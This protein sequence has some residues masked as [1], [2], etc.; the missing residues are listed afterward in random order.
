[1]SVQE[2]MPK[3][4]IKIDSQVL[5]PW[6]E[7]AEILGVSLSRYIE[8]F[9]SSLKIQDE[10][11]PRIAQ[12][13]EHLA[14][15]RREQAEAIAERFE[16]FAIE[17]QLEGRRADIG[18]IATRIEPTEDGYWTIKTDYLSPNGKRWRSQ[19]VYDDD[20]ETD[21]ENWK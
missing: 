8:E 21:G 19:S 18:T 3:T 2:L 12:E 13:V 5:E 9:L 17:K 11:L 6:C 4:T 20:D 14:Y 10:G 15:R 16:A 7:I 1:M